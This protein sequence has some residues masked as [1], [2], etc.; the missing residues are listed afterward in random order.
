MRVNTARYNPFVTAV[1]T[2]H[3][4][5]PAARISKLQEL[6]RS[7]LACMLWEDTFYESGVEIAARIA[8]LVQEVNVG[9]VAKLAV[10][11]R[12]KFKLRHVPLLLAVAL[13]KRN[14]KNGCIA[15]LVRDT[16]AEVIQRPDEL[17]EILA[18]YAKQNGRT[19]A[20]KLNKLSH[21]LARGI[22]QAFT[23]F[24]EYRLA[25]YNRD[26]EIKLR[27]VLF[28]TRPRSTNRAV[29]SLWRRLAQNELKTP[30]TWEVAISAAHNEAQKTEE[31]T[32]LLREQK[33]GALALLRNLRNMT[34]AKVDKAVIREALSN[35]K[36]ER[37]LPFRFIAA[38][39]YAPQFEDVLEQAMFKCLEDYP[40]LPGKTIIVI[41]DSGSMVDKLSGKSDLNRKDAAAALAILVREVCQEATVIVFGS[42]AK[43]VAPRRGF[44]LKEV[45]QRANV[46]GS[47]Q[48]GIALQL[49]N[50]EGYDRIIVIT[51][52]QSRT[53]IPN[54]LTEL[55]YFI[56]VA[57]YKR[58]IGYGKWTHIDGFSESVLDYIREYEA[59]SLGNSYN[60]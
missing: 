55:A 38:A 46:G 37:V 48:T 17:A 40:R 18:I 4:G 27:D 7:V 19:G 41:D 57:P 44:A 15:D 52:E 39:R 3:E 54:P 9:S 43:V 42:E 35:I 49:A 6:R 47:T 34:E 20:K 13:A 24:D 26:N 14:E 36:T 33:L 5:A 22:A 53:T 56:N 8:D 30:D 10:E 60:S 1:G 25:K 29:K 2:T 12:G 45:I 50:R 21:A 51:D 32:R 31:W 59:E 16:V 58:G 28:L 23:K 11:A